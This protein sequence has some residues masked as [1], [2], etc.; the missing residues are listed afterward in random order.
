M[1]SGAEAHEITPSDVRRSWVPPMGFVPGLSARTMNALERS[2]LG[3][4]PRRSRRKSERTFLG[5]GCWTAR[6]PRGLGSAAQSRGRVVADPIVPTEGV[7]LGRARVPGDDASARRDR[8]RRRGGRHHR[9]GRADGARHLRDGRSGG[10][11]RG[12][13]AA[14]RSAALDAVLGNSWAGKTD[15]GAS[16]SL[17]SPI[18]LQAVKAAGVTFVVSLLERVIEEQARGDKAKADALRRDILGLIGTDLSQLVPG[19]R[20]GD[21]G[22]G[23]ADRARRLEPV[24]RSGHRAGRGDLHQVPADGVGRLWRRCRHPADLGV[25]QS[26]AGSGAGGRRAAAGSSA[27]RSATTS[28][29]ATSRAARRCCSARPRTTT[30]RPRSARSSGCSTASFTI[31]DVKAADIALSVDR[32]GRVRARRHLLDEPDFALAGIDRRGDDR[33]ASPVSG[34]ARALSRHDVRAGEGSRRRPARASPTS[35]ATSSRSRRRCSGR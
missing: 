8:A 25:E 29:C 7:L 23:D 17:L 33:P 12:R 18:D 34:R 16:P 11:C 5:V 19:L 21:E 28:T 27:R 13:Q 9:Q 2:V 32:R 3:Q 10:L 15:A 1:R 31:D 30:R 6:K 20:H 35:S 24:S 14:R 22:Q 4:A 26:R